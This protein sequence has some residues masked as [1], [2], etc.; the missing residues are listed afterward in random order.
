MLVGEFLSILEKKTSTHLFTRF[1]TVT[2]EFQA[3]VHCEK[4]NA[5]LFSVFVVWLIKQITDCSPIVC[6]TCAKVLL[7][8]RLFNRFNA[9]IFPWDKKVHFA[10]SDYLYFGP[11]DFRD[12]FFLSSRV[13]LVVQSGPKGRSHRIIFT[14]CLRAFLLSETVHVDP[15]SPKILQQ[16]NRCQGNWF[17]V[18]NG[19]FYNYNCI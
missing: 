12:A 11:H 1:L 9:L 16:Y 18:E 3:H 19:R 8:H 4:M 7:S 10:P 15:S 13:P 2:L 6:P 14:V 17:F 5:V